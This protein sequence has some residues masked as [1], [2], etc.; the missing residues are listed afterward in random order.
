VAA[1]PDRRSLLR[2][3]RPL[4][5]A[6]LTLGMV[7]ASAAP[8]AAAEP[9]QPEVVIADA[10][11]PTNMALAP[12]GRLFY[13][14]KETGRVRVVTPGGDL[15]PEPFVTLPV[16]GDAERGLLGIA[17]HPD[18]PAQP[19]VYLYASDASDGR[20]RLFRVAANG[21]IADGAPQALL[22]GLASSAGYHN[23]GDLAFGTDGMLYL[24]LG[25][26]HDPERAQDPNDLGGKIVRLA[27]DGSVP[28]DQPFGGANP[29]WSIGHRNSFGLCVDPAEGTLYETENGPDVD[30]EV[31]VIEPG[32]DYGWPRVTGANGG[33]GLTDPLLTFPDTIALTGCAVAGGSLL[34]GSFGESAI[35][36]V[37]PGRS[38]VVAIVPGGITD[39]QPGPED[40]LYVSTGDT[41]ARIPVDT[42][43]LRATD[44]L[45]AAGDG[46]NPS[47]AVLAPGSGVPTD[48]LEPPAERSALRD[49]LVVVAG[50]ALVLGLAMRFV[51]G[52]RLRRS[53]S[54]GSDEDE[55]P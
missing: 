5:G 2:H 3:L 12:D 9:A 10:A 51:G 21:N 27:P 37:T 38:R 34:V 19:W 39:L 47:P 18:F 30:D 11:F 44:R 41:I 54:A 40:T 1:R 50:A 52:R 26:A 32:A 17:L 46:T 42:L 48:A 16:D 22:D 15:L 25:E 4:A 28:P 53:L 33:T 20:N 36:A 49:W 7:G 43:G 24:A 23:G 31:N 13:T 8:F 6:I 14:E 35:R 55:S 45:V 29:V